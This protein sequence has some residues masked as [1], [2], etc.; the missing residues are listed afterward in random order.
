[1]SSLSQSGRDLL[2]SSGA[3]VVTFSLASHLSPAFA[4]AIGKTVAPDEVDGFLAEDAQGA[5]TVYSGKVDLGTGVHR[6]D[7]D[8]RRGARRADGASPSSRATPL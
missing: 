3:L 4:D 6:A 5:V 7:A 1:M 8:R 2:K